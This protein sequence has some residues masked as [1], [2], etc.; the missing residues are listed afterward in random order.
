MAPLGHAAGA[1]AELYLGRAQLKVSCIFAF[2][3]LGFKVRGLGFGVWGGS[4]E[5]AL[6]P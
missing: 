4:R 2:Q 3:G 1:H 5:S 6:H